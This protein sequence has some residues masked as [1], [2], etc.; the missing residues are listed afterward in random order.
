MW[1]RQS[2]S[3]RLIASLKGDPG[4]RGYW[5]ARAAL[6]SC[7]MPLFECVV[8]GVPAASDDAMFLEQ[9]FQRV[10]VKVLLVWDHVDEGC[11]VGEEVALVLV[12]QYCRDACLVEL[13][14]LVV[15]FNKTN[16]RI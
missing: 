1:C 14:L 9:L 8:F 3:E 13:D 7:L 4:F 11:Q 12:C 15:Y 6:V 10:A 16:R 5:W 2:S